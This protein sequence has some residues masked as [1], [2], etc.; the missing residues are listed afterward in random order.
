MPGMERGSQGTGLEIST[1]GRSAK[2]NWLVMGL[3]EPGERRRGE[4]GLERE[5]RWSCAWGW[6]RRRARRAVKGATRQ[7]E[8]R[9]GGRATPARSLAP[10]V[11]IWR[12]AVTWTDKH[13][14]D[15]T[16]M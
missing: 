8:R 10:T 11:W 14:S 5:M 7:R 9:A 6:E 1:P 16:R 2:G 13:I 15:P 12:R 4:A 3:G